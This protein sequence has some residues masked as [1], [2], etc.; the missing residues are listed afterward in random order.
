MQISELGGQL[1]IY[2]FK[3][4]LDPHVGDLNVTL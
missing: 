3:M 4:C 1:R 2:K